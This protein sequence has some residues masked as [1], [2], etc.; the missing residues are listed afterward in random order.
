[1][2]GSASTDRG[3]LDAWMSGEAA[4][5]A[6]NV[7]IYRER[8]GMREI[9]LPAV[10]QVVLDHLIGL[11][12]IERI[13]GYDKALAFI[14]N[15]LPTDKK[16]RSADFGEIMAAEYVDQLTEFYVPLKKLRYSDDRS[17]AMRGDDVVGIRT[18]KA[19]HHLMKVEAK[20]HASLSSTTVKSASA[21]LMKYSGRPNPATLAFL[22]NQL[23][24]LGK[25]AEAEI[26]EAIQ[27]SDIKDSC[28][29]HLVFTCSA[30]EP[31]TALSA[32]ATSPNP[33][34][35]RVLVGVVVVDHQA[36]IQ[37]IFEML[38]G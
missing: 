33:K 19:G 36:L 1:M 30:N 20:S 15:R 37:S 22:S 32:H 38:H 8:D 4:A 14:R 27:S 2:K 5:A 29:E 11:D 31:V 24:L 25:D 28:I 34:I 6:T 13:G 12:V 7:W 35:K 23:R 17:V 18:E 10:K 21:A 16:I 9:V 3:F 26:I